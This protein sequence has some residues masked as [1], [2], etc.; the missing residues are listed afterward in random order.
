MQGQPRLRAELWPHEKGTDN[1]LQAI[2]NVQMNISYHVL[3]VKKSV[4]AIANLI[5]KQE[6]RVTASAMVLDDNQWLY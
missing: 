4:F 3:K 6:L 1:F 5:S 2:I